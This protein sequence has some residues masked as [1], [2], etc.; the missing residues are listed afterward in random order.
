M[1][2]SVSPTAEAREHIK[3]LAEV[4][5]EWCKLTD[6]DIG[7]VLRFDRNVEVKRVREK[8]QEAMAQVT[9]T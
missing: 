2:D 1:V 5:P 8:V 9:N 6:L 4:A 7:T 3:L